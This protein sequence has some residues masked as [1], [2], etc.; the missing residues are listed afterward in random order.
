[1]ATVRL[2]N[3]VRPKQINS[4]ITKASEE[5]YDNVVY[6]DLHLDLSMT[7]SGNTE[8]KIGLNNDIK[9]DTNENAIRNAVKNCIHTKKGEKVLDPEFGMDIEKYLFEPLSEDRGDTIARSI[10]SDLGTQEPRINILKIKVN[11]NYDDNS[12]GILI[13]YEIP[14]INKKINDEFT[15]KAK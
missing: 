4:S 11:V 6:S 7:N 8:T 14:K 2:D 13:I 10:L 15:L 3:L 5:T 1:M 9:I 12:Y